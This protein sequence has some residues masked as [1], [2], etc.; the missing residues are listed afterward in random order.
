MIYCL[1]C[2]SRDA[3]FRVV[4]KLTQRAENF[5]KNQSKRAGDK[6]WIDNE[7]NKGNF[8]KIC[9]ISE[10]Q[11]T[12]TPTKDLGQSTPTKDLAELA[13]SP[14]RKIENEERGRGKRIKFQ[15][16]CCDLDCCL[17]VRRALFVIDDVEIE[18]FVHNVDEEAVPD[19]GDPN[20]IDESMP[21]PK[22]MAKIAK[23]NFDCVI[24]L[25]ERFNMPD[26]QAVLWWN[27][28]SM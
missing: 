3:I 1:I 2:R 10:T 14:K 4:S 26:N 7:L 12:S 18:Q 16:S 23:P 13:L 27:M 25:Q 19:D 28:V 9:D 11:S 15:K 20:Y 5:Y 17:P 24:A 21:K 22:R 8:L 6:E